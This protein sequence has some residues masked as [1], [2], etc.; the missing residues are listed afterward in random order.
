MKIL[1]VGAGWYGCHLARILMA[2]GCDVT[3]VE[4][5]DEIFTRA[6]G[7]NQN[8]L[9]MGFHYPR[10]WATRTQ[11]IEGFYRF[12]DVYPNLCADIE[13]NIYA[14]AAHG[15]LVDFGTFCQVMEASKIPFEHC[16]AGAL[17]LSAVEG[18]VTCDE[19]LILT[20]V[21][22]G[23][24]TE[25]LAGV[26]QCGRQIEHV[27]SHKDHVIVDGERFDWL[28]N[29]TWFGFRPLPHISCWYEPTLMFAYKS[30]DPNVAV[31]IMDGAFCSI[32]P[33]EAGTITLSSVPYTPQGKFH[34]YAEAEAHLHSFS[35]AEL[36]RI[37]E[38]M[39][40]QVSQYVPS[41]RDRHEYID[42]HFSIKTKM[43]D[44]TDAR[45][46]YVKR[47]NRE[48]WVFSGKIDTIF[49]AE[50]AIGSMF[51]GRGSAEGTA[52]QPASA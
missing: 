26:L 13:R 19:K 42:T 49:V 25:T 18:A 22:K 16:D 14:V 33:Y 32:Y 6:S 51:E 40:E 48:V 5:E 30:A 3:L 23:Y 17:G 31:T 39:E 21:A 41:F 36:T 9:H 45:V 52:A 35:K 28:I 4:K 34:V 2:K 20:R 15:S 24:F 12:L 44:L 38:A 50:D 47:I 7:F 11:T 27:E 1:V 43:P 29:T 10:S 37:R 46:C 8:R